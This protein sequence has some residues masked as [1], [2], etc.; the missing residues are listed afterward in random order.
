MSHAAIETLAYDAPPRRRW[1]T[2]VGGGATVGYE[3][4]GFDRLDTSTFPDLTT[5]VFTYDAA[6]NLLKKKTRKNEFIASAYDLRGLQ[7]RNLLSTMDPG[8]I[9]TTCG[10]SP[11]ET[12]FTYDGLGRHLQVR[13]GDGTY[14]IDYA[15][16]TAGRIKDVTNSGTRVAGGP[17]TVSYQLDAGTNV[18]RITQPGGFFVDQAFD[19]RSLMTGINLNGTLQ[20]DTFTYDALARRTLR[21][22]EG[23][24]S[25]VSFAYEADSALDVLDIDLANTANDVI[26]N[27]DYTLANQMSLKDITNVAY[28]YDGTGTPDTTYAVNNLNQYPSL[29]Q[30]GT[31]ITLSYDLNGNLLSDGSWSYT[32]DIENRLVTADN[33]AAGHTAAIEYDPFGSFAQVHGPLNFTYVA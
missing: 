14:I 9:T 16:D 3:C 27:F 5:E 20:L 33:P 29:N 19:V 21:S 30:A 28:E 4:D 11:L 26:Y 31:P 15:Y 18:T 24:V 7:I 12:C 13:F 22:I 32:Y 25:A 2:I 1:P 6:N 23:G 17:R 8:T 10:V